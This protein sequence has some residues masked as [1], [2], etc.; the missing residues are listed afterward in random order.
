MLWIERELRGN[1]S[2]KALGRTVGFLL[3]WMPKLVNVADAMQL[4][5]VFL[6][7]YLDV[8]HCCLW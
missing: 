1:L 2:L 3:D 6:M 7:E 4:T 8:V 5:L